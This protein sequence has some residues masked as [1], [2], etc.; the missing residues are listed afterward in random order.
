MKPRGR[1]DRLKDKVS[2]KLVSALFKAGRALKGRKAPMNPGQAAP[3]GTIYSFTMKTI[4]GKDKPLSAYKGRVL[5]IVNTASLCGLTPQYEGLEKL[6]SQYKD[7]GLSVLAF[8]ANEFG[9]QEPG[10]DSQIKEFCRTRF[11]VS[12]DLFS[13]IVVK[14]PG[15]HPLYGYLT[16]RSGHDGDITWN[17]EKFLVSRDGRVAA[18]FDPETEPQAKPLIRELETLLAAAA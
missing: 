8:P 18:R 4:D 11:S 12:F 9:A 3:A 10:P 14:G 1:V 17:F 5:L 15:R 13:K 6:Y 7:S 2:L 16:E